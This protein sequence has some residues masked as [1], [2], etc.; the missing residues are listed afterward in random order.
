MASKWVLNEDGLY[1]RDEGNL[2]EVSAADVVRS[3]FKGLNIVNGC[4]I[5][6]RPSV[7]FPGIR[8]HRFPAR[9]GLRVS[10][11]ASAAGK[12][13]LEV[14][15]EADG[16]EFML[17][18]IP[19]RD[20]VFRGA[21]WFPLVYDEWRET[22]GVLGR[23]NVAGPGLLTL[24]QVLGL[25]KESPY[26]MSTATTRESQ[27]EWQTTR[28]GHEELSDRL[29]SMGFSFHLR[30]YQLTGVKWM[31]DATSEGFGILLADE[32]GLG[33]TAQ[34][35]AVLLLHRDS[36]HPSLIVVPAT[37]MENWLRELV[38]FAPSLNVLVHSGSR[39]T[40][41][42]STIREYDIVITSYDLAVRDQAMFG[43]I[44]WNFIVL[45]EAQAIK[46]PST[47]RAEVLKEYRRRQ[48]IS[49]T[50]TPVEN[51]LLD[52]WSVMD[53]INPG[54]LGDRD[55]FEAMFAD[56]PGNAAA[57]ETIVSPL[58][59]RRRAR[60]VA[61]DL[62]PKMIIPHPV[63][64]SETEALDY[65]RLRLATGTG[66]GI[67]DAFRTI[68]R[69]RQ[70]CTHPSLVHLPATGDP[71]VTSNKYLRLVEILESIFTGGQKVIVFVSYQ[72]MADIMLS[73]LKARFRLPVFLIDGRVPVS[74]RQA[75]ID[76]FSLVA[77]S[78]CL[79]LNPKAAGV[80]L[81]ITAANHVVH[82]NLEWNPA[83]EDQAT[84][85]AHRIGQTVPVFVYR[86]FYPGTVD[87]VINEKLEKKRALSDA[88]II[89]TDGAILSRADIARALSL[90]PADRR[91]N[92]RQN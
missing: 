41:F 15:L 40:G 31:S 68:I 86:L 62:P 79:I 56:D 66:S 69:L 17:T 6:D 73:D 13:F 37:I 28:E 16:A 11:P 3:E 81:N 44:D 70:F 77:G 75:T 82:Y 36:S 42:P 90:S 59:L 51:R 34:V 50:G 26:M 65:E 47:R 21:D 53:F 23:H 87:E 92:V 63:D 46:N 30:P 27:T 52:I 18:A 71:A 64:I 33:K 67:G 32:M 4:E 39:R 84:A 58:I 80:G 74:D 7:V 35:L 49:V 29:H 14:W 54:L 91:R 9:L 57:L 76:E 20:Q 2:L 1:T 24:R 85:R 83:I 25:L 22:A 19:G 78:A 89:G 12:P 60:E 45:D 8:F 72:M 5:N 43:M 38:K 88:A 48:S 61:S 55:T 10:I